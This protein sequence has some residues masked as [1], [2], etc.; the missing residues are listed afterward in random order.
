LTAACTS[1]TSD[2]P[3]EARGRR[4]QISRTRIERPQRRKLRAK[5]R[6]PYLKYSDRHRHVSQPSRSQI[7]QI[8]P[9]EQTRRRLGQKDL[10]TM[11]SGHHPRR[12]V[13]HRTE[14]VPAAQLGFAGRQ[15]HPNRQL[16]LQLPG[17]SGIHCR[18]WR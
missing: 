2:S 3:D 1:S 16:K 4:P 10:T 11:S 14:I 12:A 18:P 13:E 15:P 6:C 5:S 17:N 7:Q 8:Y 9:A